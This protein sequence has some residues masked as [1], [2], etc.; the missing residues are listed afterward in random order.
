M[1]ASVLKLWFQINFVT[2]YHWI[3]HLA[4]LVINLRI[5]F[6]TWFKAWR[7]YVKKSLSNCHIGDFNGKFDKW[8]STDKTTPEGT[9]LGNLTSE[10]G[11]V[12]LLKERLEQAVYCG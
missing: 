5:S 7:T 9:K 2:S 10:Y 3:D 1:N 11:I 6:I 8:C 4:N 12:K